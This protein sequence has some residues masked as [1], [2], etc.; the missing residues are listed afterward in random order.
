MIAPSCPSNP[1]GNWHE[2]A[3][4]GLICQYCHFDLDAF[5]REAARQRDF[6]LLTDAEWNKF[7]QIVR[8]EL[9]RAVALLAEEMR[10]A[11]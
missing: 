2:S 5:N 7:R 4:V 10:K 1:K 9:A 6:P 3:G 11:H 8:E